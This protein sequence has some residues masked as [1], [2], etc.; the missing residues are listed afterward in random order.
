MKVYLGGAINGCTDSECNDWR[1]AAI[2]LLDGH[3]P[4]NPMDRD[5][6]GR[7]DE[8]T[9][10]IVELDKRDIDD[11]D[12]LLVSYLKPSVGTAMEILYAWERGKPIYVFTD[13][14]RVSPWLTYHSTEILPSLETAILKIGELA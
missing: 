8:C 2:K 14:E 7:E 10:E 11:S 4:I 1:S 5:Y 13:L 12:A 9:A 6:R 3:T